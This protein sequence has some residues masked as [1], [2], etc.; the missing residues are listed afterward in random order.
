[1]T[2][3]SLIVRDSAGCLFAVRDAGPDAPQAFLAI[4]VKAAAGGAYVPAAGATETL[5][6]R[7]GCTIVGAVA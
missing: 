7:A 2:S 5:I 1:M 6:R 4:R 3:Y